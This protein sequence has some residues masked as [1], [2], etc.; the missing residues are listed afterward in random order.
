MR[1]GIRP[2]YYSS[3]ISRSLRHYFEPIVTV[4]QEDK[5]VTIDQD[6]GGCHM[7]LKSDFLRILVAR[8]AFPPNDASLCLKE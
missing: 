5:N 3:S 7:K 1:S 2:S 4:T 6:K 8:H